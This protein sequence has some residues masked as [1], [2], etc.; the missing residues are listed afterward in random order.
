MLVLFHLLICSIYAP[1]SVFVTSAVG[2]ARSLS[3]LFQS[4]TITEFWEAK[5]G[6]SHSIS[7]SVCAA[8]WPKLKYLSSTPADWQHVSKSLL[9]F[10]TICH[11]LT[12]GVTAGFIFAA[13][14]E[15][16]S[17]IVK[18]ATSAQAVFIAD[19]VR[20][21]GL[22]ATALKWILKMLPWKGNRVGTTLWLNASTGCVSEKWLIEWWFVGTIIY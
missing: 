21:Q 8:L 14:F 7:P 20:T 13:L 12:F 17:T 22:L 16:L 6:K 18:L 11:A 10:Q 15:N 2:S 19:Q 5:G 3:L 1:R 4:A 9:R